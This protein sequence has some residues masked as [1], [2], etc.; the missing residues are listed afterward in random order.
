MTDEQIRLYAIA[1]VVVP[2]GI[3]LRTYGEPAAGGVL[4][5]LELTAEEAEGR[6]GKNGPY[7]LPATRWLAIHSNVLS[8]SKIPDRVIAAEIRRAL[9]RRPASPAQPA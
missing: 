8:D 5:T 3:R 9:E 7:P 1:R 2:A 6:I 4:Y